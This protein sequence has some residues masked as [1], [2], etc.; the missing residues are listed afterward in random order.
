MRRVAYV[1]RFRE[2]TDEEELNQSYRGVITSSLPIASVQLTM[3]S[4]PSD[5]LVRLGGHS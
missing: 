3:Q 4:Q 5:L 2:H 1:S